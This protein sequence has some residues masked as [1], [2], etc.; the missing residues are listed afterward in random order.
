MVREISI[1]YIALWSEAFM[2]MHPFYPNWGRIEEE[3]S[4]DQL[5]QFCV[6]AMC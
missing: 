6:Q 1:L 3:S 5:L 4:N 2:L